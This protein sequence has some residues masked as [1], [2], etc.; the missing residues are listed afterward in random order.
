VVAKLERQLRFV[1]DEAVQ[2]ATEAA[3][4]SSLYSDNGAPAI[5]ARL[6]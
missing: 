1:V 5:A 3:D 6:T 4:P 2:I